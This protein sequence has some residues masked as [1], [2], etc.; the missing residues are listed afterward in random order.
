MTPYVPPDTTHNHPTITHLMLHNLGRK[1]TE[2]LVVRGNLAPTIK[3][4]EMDG[5]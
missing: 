3:L 5:S 1:I 4:S 2:P